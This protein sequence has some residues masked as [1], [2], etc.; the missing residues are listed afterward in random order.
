VITVS[1][2]VGTQSHRRA[3]NEQGDAKHN[4]DLLFCVRTGVQQTQKPGPEKGG[5]H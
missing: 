1:T 4:L 5:G 3:A 2:E